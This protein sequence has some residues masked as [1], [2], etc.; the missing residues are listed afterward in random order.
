MIEKSSLVSELPKSLIQ[1]YQFR[2]ETQALFISGGQDCFEVLPKA[3]MEWGVNVNCKNLS[4]F[5][6]AGP[7]GYGESTTAGLMEDSRKE[8]DYIVF[9][10]ALERSKNPKAFLQMLYE[11]LTLTALC[12]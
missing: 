9:A 7:Q 4:D 3:M 1:W 10:G 8:Y 5:E 6:M 12:L 2:E 11:L